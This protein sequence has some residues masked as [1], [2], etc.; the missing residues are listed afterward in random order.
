MT[1]S[2]IG[3]S[4]SVHQA[5]TIV[6][7]VQQVGSKRL[8]HLSDFATKAHPRTGKKITGWQWDRTAW[9]LG[10]LENQE[11]IVKGI[12]DAV[13]SGIPSNY[14]QS[15]IGYGADLEVNSIGLFPSSGQANNMFRPWY[16]ELNHGTYFDGP[17]EA[18]IFSDDVETQYA[19]FNATVSGIPQSFGITRLSNFVKPATPIQVRQYKWNDDEA[20][21]DISIDFRQRTQ[22]TGKLDIDGNEL[23]TI[24]PTNSH[25]LFHNADVSEPEFVVVYSGAIPSG[26]QNALP[27][28]ILNDQFSQAM[29]NSSDIPTSLEV[30]G[31]V[32]T[33][34]N[35][36]FHLR[37]SPLDED[38]PITIYSYA[39]NSGAASGLYTV[40]SG[41]QIDETLTTNQVNID[42]DLGLA[43]FGLAVLS[44]SNTVPSIGD[45]VAAE[46]FR[47][48]EIQYEPDPSIDTLI[49]HE[50]NVNPL[51]RHDGRDFL[52]L[53]TG[54]EDPATIELSAETALISADKYGPVYIGNAYTPIVAEVKGLGGQV[55]EGASVD[56]EITSSF[57]IGDFG[58]GV[59]TTT[60]TTNQNGKAR[61]FYYPPNSIDGISETVLSGQITVD[62]S[63]T[64]PAG[65]T[66]TTT[67]RT[68][69][70]IIEGGEEDVYLY[71]I[72]SDDEI[73]GILYSGVDS[74]NVTAQVEE[75]Y[76]R[77]FLEHGIYG[78]TG[79]DE[80]TL[81]PDTYAVDWEASRRLLW[82]LARPTIFGV[83]DG[84]RVIT[85]VLSSGALNP[86]TLA[87][88][89]IVPVQPVLL[90]AQSETE[91]DVIFDTS[92]NT[93]PVPSG[94]GPLNSYLVVAPSI[95]KMQASTYSRR[96][97][98]TITSNEIDVVIGIPPYAE[99]VWEVDLLNS[100][101]DD[102]INPLLTSLMEGKNVPLG[103]R[104]RSSNVTL[105]AALDAVTFLDIN[106]TYTIDIFD[107][108][109]VPAVGF[110]LTVSG[111]A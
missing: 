25:I 30:L 9:P 80:S 34:E 76:R 82:D 102:E 91:Y 62:N 3:V 5:A 111:S 106:P 98:S 35:Q 17:Q 15:G 94:S 10:A 28:I 7:P 12:W 79:L 43:R 50:A 4:I 27:E 42:Y 101:I 26:T 61:V 19:T 46:Y 100:V 14:F 13:P 16:A 69:Q 24:H 39:T 52:Y 1:T 77:F 22:F 105:A 36:Q 66:Q 107:V 95:V 71:Q 96:T 32:T 21:Y 67:F 11:A 65:L 90:V 78:P 41:V 33:D 31:T 64:V 2:Y 81:L 53:T 75:Y 97:G 83:G 59:S 93:I 49:A 60:G 99:G 56:F 68:D 58:S 103:W 47:T 73:L 29:G 92:S 6:T 38:K 55:I 109:V 70:I 48:V 88:G 57:L 20:K 87:S 44:G 86:H 40:Y 23:P 18:F 110:Q 54:D 37:F 51:Y 8:G 63:P 85:T 45:T 74:G 104:I 89:A 84:R 72:H 108:D